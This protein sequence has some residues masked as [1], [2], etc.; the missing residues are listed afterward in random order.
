MG[1]GYNGLEDADRKGCL[2]AALAGVISFVIDCIRLLGD[3]APG[4]EDR[5]WRHIPFLLPTFVVVLV[6]FM[7]VRAI[8]RRGGG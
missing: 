5:W 4:T 6:A 1:D 8:G 3:P 2:L 7:T